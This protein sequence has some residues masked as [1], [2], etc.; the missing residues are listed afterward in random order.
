MT[1]IPPEWADSFR[2]LQRGWTGEFSLEDM[3]GY[4]LILGRLTPDIVE[5]AIVRLALSGRK[6]FPRPS[7]S[8]I[9]GEAQRIVRPD[10]EPVSFVQV[11]DAI[12]AAGRVV[13]RDL[14][15]SQAC[16]WVGEQVADELGVIP[17]AFAASAWADLR[18]SENVDGLRRSLS[19]EWESHEPLVRERALL[20]GVEPSTPEQVVLRRGRRSLRIDPAAGPAVLTEGQA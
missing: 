17:G 10:L 9:A 4:L 8:D 20:A 19:R 7:A 5:A 12:R 1:R 11:W 3:D 15:P 16:R 6:F 14:T 13:P 18:R 2:A